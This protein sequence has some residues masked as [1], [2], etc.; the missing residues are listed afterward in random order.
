MDIFANFGDSRSNHSADIRL[1]H[2]VT[3]IDNDDH[4]AGVRRSSRKGK[5]R[6]GVL[7]RNCCFRR[8]SFYKAYKLRQ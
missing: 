4:D 2:F 1:P 8:L 7:P 6:N 3:N 5:T